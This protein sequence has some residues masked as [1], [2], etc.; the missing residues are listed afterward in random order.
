MTYTPSGKP[1]T[2]VPVSAEMRT[3][4]A[5]IKTEFDAISVYVGNAGLPL[6]VNAGETGYEAVSAASMRT[7]LGLVIGTDV[8]A[9]DADLTTWAGVTPG[10]GVATALAV[11]VGSA[12]ALVANGGALGTPSSGTL[13]NVT[14]LP[15]AGVVGTAL[16]SAAIGTTVQ[17]YDADLTTWA[18]I[19]PAANI[20]TFLTTPSSANLRAAI[21]DESGTGALLFANGDMGTPSALVGT[22]ITGTAAG[23]SIGGNAA[24]AT[25]A[26]SATTATTAG[27]P[28]NNK[29]AN[30]TTVIGD[31]NKHIL[32]PTTDNNPRTFTIDSN[33]NV[34]YD[35]GTTL[36]FVNKINIVTIAITTDT[37]TWLPYVTTGSR[38]LAAGGMATALKISATEWVITGVGL[39]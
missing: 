21:T 4:F 24:T 19:T 31:A 39:T 18:G 3:E 9:Y 12:G 33:A 16:V 20:G 26:T 27:I 10:T 13:T 22:N 36:T 5:N 34:A 38:T 32:H 28:Q 30:Y 23:L 2:G 15:A 17:A 6:K 8:Q 1:V 35:I 11:N 37:L 14:G 25:T 7:T 29:S